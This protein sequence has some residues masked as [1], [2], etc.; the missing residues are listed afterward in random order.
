MNNISTNNDNKCSR[1]TAINNKKR[2]MHMSQLR[3]QLGLILLIPSKIISDDI[4]FMIF[5]I[6][7]EC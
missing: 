1:T 2:L 5:E 6:L 4:I 3:L 7:N